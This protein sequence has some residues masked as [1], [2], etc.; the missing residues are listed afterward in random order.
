VVALL[1][2]GFWWLGKRNE[3]NVSVSLGSGAK[4]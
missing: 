2:A 3:H 1:L 4:V